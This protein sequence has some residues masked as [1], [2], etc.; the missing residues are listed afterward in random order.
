LATEFEVA[1]ATGKNEQQQI[2]E[3]AP[4]VIAGKVKIGETMNG[5]YYQLVEVM[6]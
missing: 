1:Q 2:E 4:L 5:I 3:I 6:V